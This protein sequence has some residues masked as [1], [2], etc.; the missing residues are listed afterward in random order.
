MRCQ[1]LHQSEKCSTYFSVTVVGLHRRES[2]SQQRQQ[3]VLGE[4]SFL[5]ALCL[6]PDSNTYCLCA[7]K[8]CSNFTTFSSFHLP[9][10][11]L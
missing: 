9:H 6:I 3:K 10:I 11:S 2:M 5:L 4:V 8:F 7:V 1:L